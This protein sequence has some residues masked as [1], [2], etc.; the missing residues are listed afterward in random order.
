M[1]NVINKVISTAA[2]W[3]KDPIPTSNREE[4]ASNKPSRDAEIDGQA[5]QVS[6]NETIGPPAT[7]KRKRETDSVL[8]MDK[9][10]KSIMEWRS[11]FHLPRSYEGDLQVLYLVRR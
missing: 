7:L 8:V 6:V 11:M 5:S 9:D 4:E 10:Q 2:V 1:K 3:I